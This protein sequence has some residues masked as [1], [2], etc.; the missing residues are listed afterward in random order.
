MESLCGEHFSLTR[1]VDEIKVV[2]LDVH[3]HAK[4]DRCMP[5]VSLTFERLSAE[6]LNRDGSW[7]RKRA[8]RYRGTGALIWSAG[9]SEG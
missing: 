6:T 2:G 8:Q 9:I 1:C 4:S 3:G 5:S 7:K